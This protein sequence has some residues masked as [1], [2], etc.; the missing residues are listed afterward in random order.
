MHRDVEGATGHITAFDLGHHVDQAMRERD[1]TGRNTKDD[2]VLRA[3]VTF[4]DL[5]SHASQGP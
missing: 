5:V 2:K 4:K 1:A 3:L